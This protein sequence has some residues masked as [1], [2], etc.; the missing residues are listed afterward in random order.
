MAAAKELDRIKQGQALPKTTDAGNEALAVI[1]KP[2]VD[3]QAKIVEEKREKTRRVI[4]D[5]LS[6]LEAEKKRLTIAGA[7]EEAV[8]MDNEIKRVNASPEANQAGSAPAPV[9]V[10]PR[11]ESG[12]ATAQNPA[13]PAPASGPAAPDKVVAPAGVTFKPVTLR[14]TSL[15]RLGA[16]NVTAFLGENSNI[17]RNRSRGYS[18]SSTSRTGS[19]DHY[20]R[21]QM[22]TSTGK[23]ALSN[24]TVAVQF[25]CRSA[26][27]SPG[28]IAPRQFGVAFADLPQ[29]DASGSS[30]DLAPKSLYRSTYEYRSSY[31]G[32]SYASGEEFYGILVSLL[33]GTGGVLFQGS[34]SGTL[35]DFGKTA[36]V[37]FRKNRAAQ[38]LQDAEQALNAA[39]SAYYSNMSDT[40]LRERY[41]AAQ[42]RV[43]TLRSQQ[44]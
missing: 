18:S 38:E 6:R 24:V 43:E 26:G 15:S 41:N 33:D 3:A 12:P 40:R 4:A 22:R 19:S 37:D 44:Q 27:K 1:Q 32:H 17:D 42:S 7:L 34:S 10:T 25:F 23:P 31:Y 9:S 21:L 28:K 11:P 39:R 16:V 20:V 29:V 35:D 30:V 14:H 2:F 36:T 13:A 5:Y 8:A